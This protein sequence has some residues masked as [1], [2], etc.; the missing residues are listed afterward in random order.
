[1]RDRKR[2]KKALQPAGLKPMS[3][4]VQFCIS[5]PKSLVG[6]LICQTGFV[7]YWS[8]LGKYIVQQSRPLTYAVM[9]QIFS[10]LKEYITNVID[11]PV[12]EFHLISWTIL[13]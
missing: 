1:M 4:L 8:N 9:T 3:S 6:Y 11:P 5:N 10:T 13:E 12:I 2:K 7:T